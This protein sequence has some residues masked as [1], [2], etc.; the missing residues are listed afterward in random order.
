ML[1]VIILIALSFGLLLGIVWLIKQRLFFKDMLWHFKKMNVVV[2]GKKGT[3]KDLVY[4][5]IINA[6][7]EYYYTNL[8]GGYGGNYEHTSIKNISCEPNTYDDFIKEKVVKCKRRFKEKCDIYISDAGVYLP[9]NLDS[10]LYKRYPSLPIYYALSRQLA[11]HNIHANVQV[12]SKLW[13][14]L[15]EQADFYVIAKKTIKLPFFIATK[16]ITYEKLESAERELLPIKNRV[17]N[18]YSKAEVDQYNASNGVIRV[19]WVI[20]R[21]RA[22]KYDTRAFEKLLYDEDRLE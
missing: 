18:K 2:A 16:C 9:S 22:I 17:M 12:F 20:Q 4:Q 7:K 3:G 13:K 14:A 11:N 8:P 1:I 15:R 19:G 6:R 21:K 10:V 5:A